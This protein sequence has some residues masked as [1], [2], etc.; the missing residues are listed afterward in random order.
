MQLNK[1][2]SKNDCMLAWNI[3]DPKRIGSIELNELHAILCTRF[4]KDK[5]SLKQQV[6]IIDKAVAKI[7]ER[8][9]GGF[10]GLQKVLMIMD[11]DGDKKLSKE[12]LQ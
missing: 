7:I 11:D 12:E 10:K 8:S 3:L 6:S 5:S 2:L 9:G 4:G 1:S